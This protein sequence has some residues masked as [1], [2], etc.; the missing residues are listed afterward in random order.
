MDKISVIVVDDHPAWL[1]AHYAVDRKLAVFG[2]GLI[3]HGNGRR[4][5]AGRR[6]GNGCGNERGWRYC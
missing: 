3:L 6:R 2:Q 5:E 1:L 4:W